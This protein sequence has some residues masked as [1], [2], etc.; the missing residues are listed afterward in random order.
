MCIRDR[1]AGDYTLVYSYLGFNTQ[2]ISFTLDRNK[3]LNVEL[4]SGVT[5][6]EVVITAEDKDKNVEGTQMGTISLPVESIK[7][8]PALMGEVDV[9]KALQLLPGV[10]SAG[11]GNSGFYVRGGG[12][13]QNLILL[14]EAIVYNSGHL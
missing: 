1:P 4:T 2:E 10:L 11:E 7:T 14:D 9:L 3:E 5:F 8:L 13:D 6:K 12:P